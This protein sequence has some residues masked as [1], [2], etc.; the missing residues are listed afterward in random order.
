MMFALLFSPANAIVHGGDDSPGH[1]SPGKV[2][3][4][5]QVPEDSW[6][7]AVLETLKTI[8]LLLPV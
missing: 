7:L 2:A 3:T 1:T 4:E 6:L 5:P 8:E